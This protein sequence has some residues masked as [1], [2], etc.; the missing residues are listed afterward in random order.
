M[1]PASSLSTRSWGISSLKLLSFAASVDHLK[2]RHSRIMAQSGP[3]R[4]SSRS[5]VPQLLPLL[6]TLLM[7]QRQ[8]CRTS[9]QWI[10][11]EAWKYRSGPRLQLS[12]N[13]T[14]LSISHYCA[15]HRLC[16]AILTR[17]DNPSSMKDFQVNSLWSNW[18]RWCPAFTQTSRP[19]WNS[20]RS[21]NRRNRHFSLCSQTLVLNYLTLLKSLITRARV[22]RLSKSSQ[23]NSQ[24]RVTWKHASKNFSCWRKLL[25]KK[26]R[27]PLS[28]SRRSFKQ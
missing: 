11:R 28:R 10:C 26:S 9:Q 27:A 21:A 3:W 1:I 19:R 6:T 4:S 23:K 16:Q 25:E 13:K 2:L 14:K 24:F 12:S 17:K 8:R 20:V 15:R 7:I 18:M 5:R 22:C